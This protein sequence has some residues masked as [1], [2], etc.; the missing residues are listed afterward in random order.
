MTAAVIDAG[1]GLSLTIPALLRRQVK[2]RGDHILLACDDARL[3]Y[4]E[5]DQR[6]LRL[7]RGLVA[8]GITKG[9]H[10]A[11]LF[12]NG[13]DLMISMLAVARIGA[14]IAPLSTLSTADELR[15]LLVNSDATFLLAAQE[16]RSHHYGELLKAALPEIDFSR[17]PPLRSLTAP[18]LRRI[19]FRGPL[20]KDWHGDWSLE[21]LEESGSGIDETFME[22]VES[23]VSLADR[24]VL[25]HTSGST[26]TPK[27]VIHTHGVL[28]RHRNNINRIRRYGADDVLFSS[29]PWFWVTGF[30][31]SV[32]GTLIA[33]ARLVCSNA[34]AAVDIL[35]LLE[36][37]RPTITNGYAPTVFRLAADPSFPTR[38]L[39]SIRRGTLYPIMAPDV[40]PRD[41]TLRHE[42]YGMSEG[43]SAITTSADEGDLPEHLRGSCGPFLPGF[44]VKLVD[45]ETGKDGAAGEAG[46]LWIRGPFMMEGYYGKSRSQVFEP[47]GWWRS[48]DVGI[49][50]ADGFF[51]LKGRLNNMIKSS[52]ANVSPREVEGVL[53]GLTGGLQ[54]VVLG[55]PDQQRGQA[56]AAVVVADRDSDV[57]E[58]ALREQLADKLSSYKVPRRI[59]RFGQS[60][61]PTLSSGKLDMRKLT[62]LVQR[63]W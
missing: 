39:S 30:S 62:E 48:G 56:V 14:V 44:E 27:G 3:S 19:C 13:V 15:W 63:R 47:D 53:S 28:I 46:E 45:P 25:I 36:R 2:A 61:M 34:T 59:F 8:A 42:P 54:C 18:S 51:F 12:P 21:A 17:P 50:N 1:D 37:E 57:D 60:E 29:A 10:V 11:L 35:D 58:A 55:I 24:C 9:S 5:A 23:R 22:A 38:D 20:P 31:F 26:G 32:I 52:F 4:A 40:R 33:G 49:I 16:F 6:S 43:G 41:P 7:A